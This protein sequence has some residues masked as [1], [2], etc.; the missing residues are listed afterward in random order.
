M[1]DSEEVGG[2]R[3]RVR[4]PLLFG[5]LNYDMIFQGVPSRGA[6]EIR[7]EVEC[8]AETKTEDHLQMRWIHTKRR[9]LANSKRHETGLRDG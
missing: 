6:C 7:R 2:M 1:A 3:N 4:L 8:I 5:E 9:I